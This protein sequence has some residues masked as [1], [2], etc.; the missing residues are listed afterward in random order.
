ME[1]MLEA[2]FA[3]RK[4]GKVVSFKQYAVDRFCPSCGTLLRLRL[5][6]KPWVF[7]FN[8]A[9]Y[10][11][12]DRIKENRETEQWLTSRYVKDI[13]EGD[14]VA[15]WAS[16]EKAGI[17]AIGEIVTNPRKSSLNPEQEKYWT[18]INDISKFR[19]EYSVVIKYLKVIID[20]PLLE[21]E[22][23]KDPILSDMAVLKQPQGTNFILTKKEWNKIIELIDQEH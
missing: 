19:E 4:C 23:R 16:G 21:D 3:C 22:C 15:I 13:R 1:L 2:E 20:R 12:F 8:P 10:R 18:N 17:Y 11:W 7:Q 5:H 6:P 9:V 14:K